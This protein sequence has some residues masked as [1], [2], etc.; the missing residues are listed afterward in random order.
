[1]SAAVKLLDRLGRVK[2]TGSGRWL[3]RCPGHEDRSPSLSIRALDDG[4]VLI[5]CFAGCE[6]G[7]VLLA[8]G[9]TMSDLFPERLREQ[10]YAA[11]HSSIPASDLL[12]ALDHELAVAV[13]ILEDVVTRRTVSA[14]QVQR[15]CQAAARVGKARDLSHPAKVVPDAA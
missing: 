4:R 1:M 15:L 5:N 2:Q 14:G 9:L 3:A 12:I 6:P 13:L 7:D 10:S 11:Y 8:V